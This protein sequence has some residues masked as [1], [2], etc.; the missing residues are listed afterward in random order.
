MKI[1]NKKIEKKK[2]KRQID[3]P[4][5]F[6]ISVLKKEKKNTITIIRDYQTVVS[7]G[8]HIQL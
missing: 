7:F 6:S 2:R 5:Y 3:S 1:N 4:T 8:I